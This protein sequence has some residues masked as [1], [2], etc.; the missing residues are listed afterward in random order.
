[1]TL[2]GVRTVFE[3]AWLEHSHGG[4]TCAGPGDVAPSREDFEPGWLEGRLEGSRLGSKKMR[5][6]VRNQR[7]LGSGSRRAGRVPWRL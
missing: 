1:M 5:I 4:S 7:R 3:A 2:P 6:R